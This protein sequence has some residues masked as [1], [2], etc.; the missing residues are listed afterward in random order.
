MGLLYGRAGRIT[1]KN[2]GFRP[3]QTPPPTTAS[4]PS[5]RSPPTSTA[6]APAS[7]SRTSSS[8]LRVPAGRGRAQPTPRRSSR[9]RR[10]PRTAAEN[11]RSRAG[12]LTQGARGSP[13]GSPPCILLATS[14]PDDS[15]PLHKL[16]IDAPLADLKF[17]PRSRA[18]ATA[19]PT[20]MRSTPRTCAGSCCRTVGS[21]CT[22]P[23][24]TPRARVGVDVKVILTPPCIIILL[25]SLRTKS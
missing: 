6:F 9:R 7:S 10:R 12:L 19:R 20:S 3:G 2:G 1:A 23:A 14:Q 25:V 4:S 22:T 8:S 24:A 17:P 13:R 5:S 18:A 11:A 15:D 21:G 16:P